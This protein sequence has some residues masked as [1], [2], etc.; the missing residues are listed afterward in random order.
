MTQGVGN[1]CVE[2][3]KTA[4]RLCVL[5]NECGDKNRPTKNDYNGLRSVSCS[6]VVQSLLTGEKLKVEPINNLRRTII[7][8]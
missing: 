8:I 4:Q 7:M 6:R 5:K 3:A 1:S 2:W